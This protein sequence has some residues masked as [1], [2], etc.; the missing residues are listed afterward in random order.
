MKHAIRIVL[1]LAKDDVP[2]G[3]ELRAVG[4]DHDMSG[5]KRHVV[6][7]IVIVGIVAIERVAIRNRT[8]GVVRHCSDD[9]GGASGR[10]RRTLSGC[11]GNCLKQQ[12]EPGNGSAP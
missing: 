2:Q 9:G 7:V 5:K 4:T 12:E 3:L 8:I 10:R 1:R 11:G 6:V